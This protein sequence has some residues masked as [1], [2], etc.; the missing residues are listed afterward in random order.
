MG[1]GRRFGVLGGLGVMGVGGRHGEQ[2]AGTGDV[3]GA[4]AIGKEAPGSSP[5]QAPWR[6]R[7]NPEGSTWMRK[8]R[9]NSG[10]GRVMVLYRSHP[11]ARVSFHLKVTF[12]SLR[13]IR[14]LLAMAI[15]LV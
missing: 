2:F 14:R 10:I 5:G 7:W 6:M 3:A 13:E 11:W 1:E 4:P 9:M 8:R 15:R 12:L